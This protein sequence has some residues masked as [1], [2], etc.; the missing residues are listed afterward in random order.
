MR[1]KQ[2]EAQVFG[3]TSL[4]LPVDVQ[5]FPYDTPLA[6]DGMTNVQAEAAVRKRASD[7]RLTNRD[8]PIGVFFDKE[9]Q[10]QNGYTVGVLNGSPLRLGVTHR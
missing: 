5:A 7:D 6:V 4:V 1:T 8:Y 10:L 2:T 3:D 9:A